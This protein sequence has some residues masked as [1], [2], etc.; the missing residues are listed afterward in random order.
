MNAI[1]Q[2]RS[3][4][5]EQPDTPSAHGLACLTEALAQE[6]EFPLA[7]LYE[8]DAEAFDLAIELLRDWR[9]DRYYAARIKLFDAVLLAG[10]R[11][12]SPAEGISEVE[13]AEESVA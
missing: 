12:T 1:K 3:F 7:T 4:L 5:L 13:T 10:E 11:D 8:L 9:L 2:V 6:G